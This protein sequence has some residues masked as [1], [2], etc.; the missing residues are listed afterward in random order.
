MGEPRRGESAST[1]R[2]RDVTVRP[3]RADDEQA[4]HEL[5]ARCLPDAFARLTGDYLPAPEERMRRERSWTGP[6]GAP[7]PRHALLVA[8]RS[9]RLAGFAATGP[10]RDADDDGRTTG[11][12][13]VVMVA[14]G[15]RGAGVGR[16]LIAAGERAM[17][18]CG[19]RVATLWVVPENVR[20]A[21]CYERCG[22]TAD[23]A[24]RLGD[25]GGRMIRSV[26]YRKWLTPER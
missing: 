12:L 10:T 18:R 7:H 1:R 8:E 5:V 13:R 2:R 14:A 19:L 17:R 3:A 22:W 25:F 21:R 24:E 6:I 15:D 23:G 4:I 9:G 20:A 26:R 16:E 11:E